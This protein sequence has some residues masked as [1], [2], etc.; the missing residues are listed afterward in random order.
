MTWRENF[1][2]KSEIYRFY[3]LYTYIS[4]NNCIQGNLSLKKPIGLELVL[5]KQHLQ[6]SKISD[7]FIKGIGE[8]GDN[9]NTY[10]C[11]FFSTNEQN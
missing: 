3:F 2:N 8:T 10:I 7:I 9:A 6:Y 11:F 1:W 5:Y 4:K